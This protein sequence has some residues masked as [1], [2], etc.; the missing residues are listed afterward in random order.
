[1]YSAL[2]CWVWDSAK[3][4]SPPLF[5]FCLGSYQNGA[6]KREQKLGGKKSLPFPL[7]RKPLSGTC[8]LV[9]YVQKL[10]IICF[11]VTP[12]FVVTYC[13]KHQRSR[14]P[15]DPE[16]ELYR[17]QDQGCHTSLRAKSKLSPDFV[18]KVLL[19][20]G[21]AYSFLYWL[22]LCSCYGRAQ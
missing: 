16:P 15:A 11:P 8:N 22:W 7:K 4:L 17:L 14:G 3:H 13:R 20:C 21:H 9:S 5:G 6:L 18:N 19:E 12:S 2:Q 1:M 10:L